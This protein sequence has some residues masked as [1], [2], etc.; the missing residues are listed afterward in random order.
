MHNGK[1]NPVVYISG[2]MSGKPDYGRKEFFLAEKLLREAGYSIILNPATMPIGLNY[3]EY[4]R[5]A[6]AMVD[7]AD[8]IVLL[9]DWKKSKG[10]TAEVKYAE[11]LS[12]TVVS[13]VDALSIA[14][15]KGA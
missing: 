8:M 12:K 2:A 3:S 6:M 14:Q 13:I 7:I 11:C 4:M 15:R 5:I 9:P 10:A 1:S